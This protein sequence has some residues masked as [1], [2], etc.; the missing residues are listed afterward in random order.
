LGAAKK[1]AASGGK[2]IAASVSEHRGSCSQFEK[3]ASS[4]P[5]S[6][7]AAARI[8]PLCLSW[9]KAHANAFLFLKTVT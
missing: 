5:A 1:Y 9:S 3:I 6:N 2:R 8:E 7:L 4:Q